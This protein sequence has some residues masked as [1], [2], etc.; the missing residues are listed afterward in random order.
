MTLTQDSERVEQA[1]L[2]SRSV[3]D[4]VKRGTDVSRMRRLR[5]TEP[6][7]EPS[8]WSQFAEFGWLATLIPEEHGGLGLGLSEQRIVLQGL[9]R[10]LTPEPLAACAMAICALRHFPASKICSELLPRIAA[11]EV[12]ATLAWQDTDELAPT[13]KDAPRLHG[14]A[15]AYELTGT[16]RFVHGAHGAS[17]F[18]VYC[19]AD[20]GPALVWVPSDSPG[21][22]IETVPLADGGRAASLHCASVPIL[23]DHLITCGAQARTVLENAL[24]EGMVMIAAE[25]CGVM[26]GAMD[27]ITSH[28]CTRVQFGKPIGSFQALAHKAVDL[29]IQQQLSSAVVDQA[30][31]QMDAGCDQRQRS[32]IASRAKAR[33]SD[34]AL[35]ITRDAIPLHG[36]MGF[37]DEF[38]IGLYLKRA[39]V[40]SSWLGNAA[41]HRRRFA[42]LNDWSSR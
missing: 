41:S 42:T 6:G 23:S 40:L 21:L 32:M 29:Y 15:D 14:R 34:A 38:D 30:V 35:R 12:I 28:L 2:L 26:G 10:V 3:D 8:M 20:A 9:A 4:F 33:C 16:S 19:E 39:I 5:D 31:A 24:D 36:A 25:L 7:F 18:V 37:T 11:G 13:T 17:G 27:M 1:A 22:R